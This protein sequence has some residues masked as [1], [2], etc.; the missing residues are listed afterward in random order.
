VN[1]FSRRGKTS[2]KDWIPFSSAFQYLSLNFEDPET[3]RKISESIQLQDEAWKEKSDHIFYLAT[4]PSFTETILGHLAEA[5]QLADKAKSR[6]V[7]EKPFGRDLKSAEHLN[8]TLA[9]IADESQV[10]RIDHFL[11][12][13][14]VQ[15]ILALRFANSLFEPIWNRTYIDSV[16]I[17]VAEKIGIEQR[18]EYYDKAGALRDMLENHLFQLMSLIAM[19]PPS[20]FGAEEI[21]NKK[22]D[23]L[24]AVR[25]ITKDQ[26]DQVA[27]RG[28]Y[29]SGKV[30]GVSV[31]DYDHESK[32]A[33]HSTTETFAALKLFIDNWRWQGVPFYLRTG[34]RMPTQVAEISLLFKAVPHRSFP[35][36][37]T[38]VWMPNHLNIRIQPEEEI[39]LR[40]Q[41][42]QPG[43][44]FVLK[45]VDM[46][47][48]YRDSFSKQSP[49]A[50]E[51]LL[52]DILNGDVASFVRADLEKAAW[53]TITPVLEAWEKTPPLDFPNYQAGSWGPAAADQLLIKDGRSWLIHGS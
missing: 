45:P 40:F 32:V 49:E 36:S 21:R 23:V 14:T 33:P 41:A 50:Y 43:T 27:V 15:N 53:S 7:I 42:K 46:K 39:F 51:T 19:E 30:D 26:V 4:A 6:V 34:K 20:S 29:G 10:F 47:F 13:E 48:S 38:S 35:A 12:K 28:Q 17:T 9:R 5:K 31:V 25:I 3:Y 18:G 2:D 37:A 24:N 22:V 44:S 11:G 52:L 16:Q 1:E 8:E